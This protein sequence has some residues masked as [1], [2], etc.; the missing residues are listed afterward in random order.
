MTDPVDPKK[1]LHE[2]YCL[3]VQNGV[4]AG[5]AATIAAFH[6]RVLDALV[7]DVAQSIT[8][9]RRSMVRRPSVCCV[10]GALFPI[11]PHLRRLVRDFQRG[12]K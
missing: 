1:K 7:K 12:E 11:P 6:L 2:R 10:S 5:Q 3:Y 8:K 9:N 4:P